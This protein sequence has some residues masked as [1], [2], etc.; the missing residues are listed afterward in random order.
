MVTCTV[1]NAAGDAV[2]WA[3][4][5]IEGYIHRMAGKLPAM[6]EAIAKF[7]ASGYRY[8]HAA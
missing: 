2:A 5:S 7:G 1:Y 3:T 4:D 8:F 6:V